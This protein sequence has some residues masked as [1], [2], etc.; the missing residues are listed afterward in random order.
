LP[1]RS[2]RMKC[3]SRPPLFQ[4]PSDFYRMV[5]QWY[6]T[7]SGSSTP[8]HVTR[9]VEY[10][11]H[12][13]QPWRAPCIQMTS[14]L[15]VRTPRTARLLSIHRRATWRAPLKLIAEC[16]DGPGVAKCSD[17]RS[18]FQGAPHPTTLPSPM[19]REAC[20]PVPGPIT[21]PLRTRRPPKDLPRG[22]IQTSEECPAAIFIVIP[23][24]SLSIRSA[25]NPA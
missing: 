20:Y 4:G 3:P 12:G 1:Y 14:D 13:N 10:F 24:A 6:I 9:F 18:G 22:T 5:S 21:A 7:L 25:S 19:D 15:A 2:R 17:A 8:L 11:P 23:P 16:C